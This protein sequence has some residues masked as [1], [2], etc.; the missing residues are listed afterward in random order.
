MPRPARTLPLLLLALGGCD[1][2]GLAQTWQLDRLR[3]LGVRAEPAEPEPGDLVA[4]EALIFDPEEPRERTV[5]W[6]ACLPESS[7]D[8][9]CTVDPTLLDSL[10]SVDPSTLSAEE[11]AQL[12]ADAQA[13]GLIGFE[14]YVAATWV[15]PADALDGLD[16]AQQE[17]GLSAL[18]NLSV[19]PADAASDADIE[20]A[21]K[22][23]PVSRAATPNHN[24]TVSGISFNGVE[25]AD[26]ETFIAKMGVIY[27]VAPVLTDDSI[28]DYSY[29]N[30][31]GVDETRT[32]EPYYTWYTRRGKFDQSFSLEPYSSV[33]WTPGGS[34]TDEL[35][36]VMRDR[37]GGMAWSR[38]SLAMQCP[39][40]SGGV[41]P[42]DGAEAR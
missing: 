22:R 2:N 25:I 15:A 36:V 6:F 33:E 40:P 29:T 17:E 41:G 8:F 28:E 27:E 19:I 34:E 39:F 18:V 21:Y 35:I 16:E 31:D 30:S 10:S 1:S 42:C 20:I 14:P 37:R 7:S 11:L 5:A 38:I 26:G 32:E 12:Y 9:G 13:A 23:V 24:P 4:F 3:V